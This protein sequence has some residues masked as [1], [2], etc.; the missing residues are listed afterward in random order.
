MYVCTHTCTYIH[1]HTHTHGFTVFMT[2][3]MF[4]PPSP[5]PLIFSSSLPLSLSLS[6]ARTSHP[7]CTYLS[8]STAGKE[9]APPLPISS[10]LAS[11]FR[12]SS[13][14]LT[15]SRGVFE[16]GW[17]STP[18]EEDMAQAR[19]AATAER[20]TKA[21]EGDRGWEMRL[22]PSST[23]ILF[24]FSLLFLFLFLYYTH[25]HTYTPTPFP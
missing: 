9:C 25:M 21:R 20:E 3:V 4:Q 12:P 11:V 24:C 5:L 17:W 16:S 14:L 7:L 18:L 22:S 10:S 13:R 19:G 2:S 15:S 1:T 8:M 6:T 23:S